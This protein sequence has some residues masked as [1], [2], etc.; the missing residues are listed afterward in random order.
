MWSTSETTP[1]ITVSTAGIYT[2]TQSLNGCISSAGAGTA[3]PKTTPLAPAVNVVDD[4]DGTSTLTASDYTGSLLWSTS[5]TTPSITVNTSGTYTVNQTLKGCSGTLNTVIITVKTLPIVSTTLLSQI[6]CSGSVTSIALTSNVPEAI[7]NWTVAESGISGATNGSG[8]TISQI[9]TTTATVA[10]TAT[11]TIIPSANGCD[12]TPVKV[13]ITVKPTPV[14]TATPSLQSIC[15]GNTTSIA[16]TSSLP[17]TIFT[18]TFNQSGVFGAADGTGPVI[19][20][21]LSITGTTTG[22]ATY[23]VTSDANA[24]AGIPVDIGVT[25]N[26][27]PVWTSPTSVT[28]CSN[29]V[30]SYT[31]TSNVTGTTFSWS[32]SA[33]LGILNSAASGNDNPNELLININPTPVI[34]NYNYTMNLNGCINTQSVAVSVKPVSSLLSSTTQTSI[35]SNTIFGYHP[36]SSITGTVISWK[37]DALPGISNPA[38]TGA[39]D[40]S[41]LLV[42]TSNADIVVS[43]VY[44]LSFGGCNNQQTVSVIVKPL[45]KVDPIANVVVCKG[46]TVAATTLNCSVPT[47]SLTW[48]NSAPANG[49]AASGTTSIPS[50]TSSSDILF[51]PLIL[52]EPKLSLI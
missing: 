38:A 42:N 3:A 10:G 20:Q 7:F 5:E 4:C 40:I 28:G 41:E 23:K 45:P 39:G 15:T 31:P 1:S 52:S 13:V 48:T 6:I 47:A 37:R 17:G 14:I 29:N 50:F 8:T 27:I 43:Y 19:A 21:A 18:W 2:A 34:A 49:L 9:L 24:C 30:F 51:S 12:G 44:T 22:I 11:Y 25:V 33:V 35:C 26:P 46:E 32:R 36:V 16:L